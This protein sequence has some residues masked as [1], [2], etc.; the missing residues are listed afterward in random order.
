M[1]RFLGFILS[2]IGGLA[3]MALLSSLLSEFIAAGTVYNYLGIEIQETYPT[4]VLVGI[5]G[6]FSM[7]VVSLANYFKSRF[8]PFILFVVAFVLV[9]FSA[10]IEEARLL[11]ASLVVVTGSLISLSVSKKSNTTLTWVEEQ[12]ESKHGTTKTNIYIQG[13]NRRS[14]R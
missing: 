1:K 5:V 6:M 13:T 8:W 4:L 3:T 2:L 11:L 7:V 14:S 10:R 9:L 12:G